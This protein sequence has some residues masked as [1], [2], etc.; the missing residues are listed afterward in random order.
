MTEI[1]ITWASSEDMSWI[2]ATYRR[3]NFPPS[4]FAFSRH[5]L[6][7]ESG[8][9]RV[10]LI[11]WI[12]HADDFEELGGLF[13][14]PKCRGNGLAGKLIA[15]ASLE[16]PLDVALYCLPLTERMEL[17]ANAGFSRLEEARAPHS[18]LRLLEERRSKYGDRFVIMLRQ[19]R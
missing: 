12:K 11:R 8:G 6:A 17:Y 3:I 4:D 2:D 16:I 15:R 9:V 14:D 13:V 5:L 1:K 18:L 19:N 7:Y 10:G